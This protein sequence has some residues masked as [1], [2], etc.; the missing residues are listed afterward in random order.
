V[1]DERV[2]R[3]KDGDLWAQTGEGPLVC[4]DSSVLR[5]V[6][7][8]FGSHDSAEIEINYGPL[9]ELVPKGDG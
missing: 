3:D 8:K 2:F 9:A 7:D 4:L 5:R 6:A 1:A